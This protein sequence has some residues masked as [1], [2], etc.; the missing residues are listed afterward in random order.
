MIILRLHITEFI[1]S[2][3]CPIYKTKRFKLSEILEYYL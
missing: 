1:Q 2:E 3:D